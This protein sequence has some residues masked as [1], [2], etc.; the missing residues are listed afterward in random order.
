MQFISYNNKIIFKKRMNIKNAFNVLINQSN[1]CSESCDWFAH[2][3]KVFFL[4][5]FNEVIL[6]WLLYIS[7]EAPNLNLINSL[8]VQVK[9][10]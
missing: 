6:P 1:C 3:F 5:I 9:V 8:D 10:R 7:F 4:Q 2:F